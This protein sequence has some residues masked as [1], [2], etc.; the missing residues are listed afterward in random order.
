MSTLE[1]FNLND[2]AKTVATTNLT[3]G[4]AKVWNNMNGTGT[5]AVRDSFNIASI[6]DTA[7]GQYKHNFTNAMDSADNFSASAFCRVSGQWGILGGVNDSTFT[8]SSFQ[9]ATL[10]SGAT[11]SADALYATIA[12]HGDLA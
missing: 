10:Q 7:T 3:N 1:V 9:H 8:A 5:V 12:I 6:T 4:S 11:T 2:C